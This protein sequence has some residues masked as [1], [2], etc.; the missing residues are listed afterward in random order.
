MDLADATIEC[1][2]KNAMIFEQLANIKPG[3][4]IIYLVD[5]INKEHTRDPIRQAAWDQYMK[6]K[7]LLVQRSIGKR[8]DDD[9]KFEYIA[10]GRKLPAPI[11]KLGG[12]Y[13][14]GGNK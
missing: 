13:A 5:N 14:A 1:I 12:C 9:R 3:Q 2:D 11:P 6:G 7:A 4:R 8:G 10:I